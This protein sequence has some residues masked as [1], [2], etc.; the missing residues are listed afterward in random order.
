LKSYIEE[1]REEAL[2]KVISKLFVKFKGKSLKKKSF[3]IDD[4]KGNN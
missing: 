3:S 2:K 4:L 1:R